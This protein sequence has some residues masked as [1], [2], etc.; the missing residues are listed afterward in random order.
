MLMVN[1]HNKSFRTVSNSENGETSSE[2]IFHYKQIGNI[3]FAD[4]QGGNIKY[5]HLLGIVSEYGT[6]EM[7]YHQVNSSGALMTGKCESIPEI[8][9]NGKIRLHEN[10]EWTSGDF[11]KGKSMVDEQ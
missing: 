8:L 11:S 4:Y 5:G 1:Y 9:D 6:I 10:W 3:V 2:T 7:T